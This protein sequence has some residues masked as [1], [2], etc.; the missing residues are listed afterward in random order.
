MSDMLDSG[1]GGIVLTALLKTQSFIVVFGVCVI[2]VCLAPVEGR[3]QARTRVK[4]TVASPEEVVV[5]A[6][7]FSPSRLWSFRNAHAGALGIAERID[8]LDGK[9][10]EPVLRQRRGP[11]PKMIK[12]RRPEGSFSGCFY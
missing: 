10:P 1:S 8:R 3:A 5:Q 6:H 2:L 4:I 11:R 12:S 7:L 9:S